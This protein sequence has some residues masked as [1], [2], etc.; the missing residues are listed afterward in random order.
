MQLVQ[1]TSMANDWHKSRLHEDWASH[2]LQQLIDNVAYWESRQ[3]EHA[4]DKFL[5]GERS[6]MYQVIHLKW[7]IENKKHRPE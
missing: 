3:A 1:P 6:A 4:A 2:P 7:R 5:L